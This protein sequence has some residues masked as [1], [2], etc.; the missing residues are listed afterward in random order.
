MKEEPCVYLFFIK[1]MHKEEN[2]MCNATLSCRPFVAFNVYIKFSIT[3][4]LPS[5]HAYLVKVILCN[6]V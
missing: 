6:Y 1:R 2:S 5:Q 4:V 3:M